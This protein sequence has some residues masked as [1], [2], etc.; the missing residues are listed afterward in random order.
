MISIDTQ[1]MRDLVS[2]CTS[3]NDA[4][5]E[6]V[7]ALAAIPSHDD[8]GCREKVRINEYTIINKSKIQELKQNADS[9]LKV[10]KQVTHDFEEAE[11]SIADSASD[12]D[13]VLGP[14]ISI[15]TPVFDSGPVKG[16]LNDLIDKPLIGQRSGGPIPIPF[17]IDGAI[18]SATN[19]GATI[20]K[21]INQTINVMEF[22]KM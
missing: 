10:L 6:A 1:L 2:G 7:S 14:I 21:T 8:W 5:E 15:P 18:S 3:A 16:A 9:F 22:G 17:P 11:N 20:G 13:S 4:I 12:V 19:L